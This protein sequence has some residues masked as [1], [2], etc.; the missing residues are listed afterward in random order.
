MN[1]DPDARYTKTHEWV[2]KDGDVY[3]Y[4]ITDHAQNALSDIVFVDLPAVGESF[5]AGDTVGVVESVKAASDLYMP[6]G[7]EV[8]AVNDSLT[9]APEAVNAD[10]YGAGWI[11]KFKLADPA[12][13]AGMLSVEDYASLIGE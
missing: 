4:G 10:P 6:V 13:Y 11:I 9:D 2:R 7:G 8:V 3:A 12:E 5:A 1:I